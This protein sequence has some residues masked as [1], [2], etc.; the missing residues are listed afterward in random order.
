MTRP[1]QYEWCPDC[2]GD[3]P[4]CPTCDGRGE[5]DPTDERHRA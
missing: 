5:I 4:E 3:D 2:E 1:G